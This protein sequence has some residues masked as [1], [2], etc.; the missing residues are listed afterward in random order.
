MCTDICR[1]AMIILVTWHVLVLP[2]F[3]CCIAPLILEFSPFS[4]TSSSSALSNLA[5]QMHHNLYPLGGY[6]QLWS[7]SNLFLI[8]ISKN[9]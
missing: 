1:E 3:K 8:L 7:A 5:L 2:R 9:R 6:L 4:C